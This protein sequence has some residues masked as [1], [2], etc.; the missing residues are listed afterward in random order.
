VSLDRRSGNSLSSIYDIGETLLDLGKYQLSIQAFD[1]I[2]SKGFKSN[3][4][5]DAQINKLYA[6]TKSIKENSEDIKSIDQKYSK[7]IDEVGVNRYSIL[8]L[9]NHA[10]FKAFFLNDLKSAIEIL[11]DI[12]I[13][14]AIDKLDLAEC[15]IQYADIMLLSGNIWDAL[16]FYSQVEKDFKEHPIGH[17]A[18]FKR[19]KIAYYQGDFTWA[20]AQLDVLK[21]STSK[22]IANDA[23]ELS[24][25]ITDNYALDTIDIPMMQFAKADLKTFQKKYDIALLT[26]DSILV[27]FQGH[28]LSDEIYYRK[29]N[30]YL[31][32]N[33]FDLYI[34]MLEIIID[35]FSY[36]ILIDDALFD[37]ATFYDGKLKNKEQAAKYYQ[38]LILN[39]QGSIFVAEARERFRILRGDNLITEK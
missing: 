33:N 38:E 24:L 12:M 25:L 13:M 34:K 29:A 30:I 21:S 17:K 8:L 11:D 37:L 36:E 3:L 31:L 15:K 28:D 16:L 22:L 9:S 32:N 4:Y 7:I 18:K 20:Q 10:H 1:Y 35:Q 39:F 27:N 5:I 14:S 19:A 6:L 23:M 2:I 26:Y